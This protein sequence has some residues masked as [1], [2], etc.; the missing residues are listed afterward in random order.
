MD[1]A[2]VSFYDILFE[3][4][5]N[6]NIWYDLSKGTDST[7]IASVFQDLGIFEIY[8]LGETYD[9]LWTQKD[10]LE[11]MLRYLNLHITQEAS[12]F[13]IFDWDTLM[14]AGSGNWYN[15]R[16]G[17]TKARQ[18]NYMTLTKDDYA[19]ADTNVSVADVFNQIM[20]TDELETIE[21]VIESPLENDS[22][23]SFYKGKTHYM[24]EY[25]AL[26]EGEGA[27]V[28]WANIVGGAAVS[29][30]NVRQVEWYF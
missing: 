21:T 14:G 12:D 15:L 10:V 26:G 13:Y 16:N 5:P 19:G 22:L 20:V 9:D 6:A 24:T 29:D 8:M 30:E 11:E 28:P 2:N 27:R 1:A 4:L 23:K 7:R 3:I 18:P 25:W 17:N